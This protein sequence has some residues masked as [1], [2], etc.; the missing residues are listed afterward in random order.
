MRRAGADAAGIGVADDDVDN[1]KADEDD[2]S[3]EED[4]EGMAE[5]PT[6]ADKAF[7]LAGVSDEAAAK[8]AVKVVVVAVRDDEAAGAG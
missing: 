3:M 6:G 8:A 1:F 4:S 5:L 7:G 2:D